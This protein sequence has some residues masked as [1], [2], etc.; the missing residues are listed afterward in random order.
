[1]AEMV[2][3]LITSLPVF[4]QSNSTRIVATEQATESVTHGGSRLPSLMKMRAPER[5]HTETA[6]KFC[7]QAADCAR[8]KVPPRRRREAPPCPEAYR[9]LPEADAVAACLELSAQLKNCKAAPRNS[10]RSGDHRCDQT[11]VTIGAIRPVGE[12][13]RGI[14]RGCRRRSRSTT[15]PP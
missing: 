7:C 1:M 2:D 15:Y 8:W 10:H 9:W 12:I 14:A 3:T 5:P 13:A 11:R 6:H 4:G